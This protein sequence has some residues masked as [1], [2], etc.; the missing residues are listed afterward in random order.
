MSTLSSALTEIA[1]TVAGLPCHPSA[2]TDAATTIHVDFLAPEPTTVRPLGLRAYRSPHD[3]FFAPGRH[4]VRLHPG[5]K[6]P[7]PKL[8]TSA[9]IKDLQLP[10]SSV[11]NLTT[12]RKKIGPPPFV[13]GLKRSERRLRSGSAP[14]KSRQR[15]PTYK[16]RPASKARNGCR[17]VAGESET[18]PPSRP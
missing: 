17:C 9:K 6:P 11:R 16:A 13:G 2:A 12:V 1:A 7:E 5:I 14:A 15:A 10:S 18:A 3:P 8:W 4:H